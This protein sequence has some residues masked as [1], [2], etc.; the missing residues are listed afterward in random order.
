[1]K[2]IYFAARTINPSATLN[3]SDYWI[4]Q[5]GLKSDL[6]FNMIENINSQSDDG[7]PMINKIVFEDQWDG[8]IPMDKEALL[9]QIKRYKEIGLRVG[10]EIDFSFK[11]ISSTRPEERLKKAIEFYKSIFEAAIE[12]KWCEEVKIWNPIR[13]NS[14]ATRELNRDTYVPFSVENQSQMEPIRLAIMQVLQNY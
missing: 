10:K 2:R 6:V 7:K 11:A 13:E 3:Y 8:D 9:Q 4:S 14:Y 12:S 5:G 1:M